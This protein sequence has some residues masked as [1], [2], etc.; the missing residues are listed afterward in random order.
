MSR[1]ARGW[2]RELPVVALFALVAVLLTR[3]HQK[4]DSPTFDEPLHVIA[5]A[6]Y[7]ENG[8]YAINLE[9]PPL[10]KILAGFSLR[11]LRV[12]PP[13]PGMRVP[14]M[15]GEYFQFL[16]GN[17]APASAI[18]SVARRPFPYLLAAL[19]LLAWLVAAAVFGEGVGLLAAGLVAFDPTFVGHAGVVHTDVGASLF[20]VA[21]VAGA[22]ASVR[23][24]SLAGW[25][26]TGVVL[27]LA[28]ATKFSAVLLIPFVAAVPFLPLGAP[29]GRSRVRDLA[30]AVAAIGV[31]TALLLATYSWAMRR[32]PL[33]TALDAEREYL[34]S[35]DAPP[36]TME[37][38]ARITH[39]SSPLGHY[40]TGLEGVALLDTNGR[41]ANYLLGRVSTDRFLSYFFVAFL[42]KSTPSFLLLTLFLVV[43][44]GRRL[45]DP[46]P[47]GLLL[48][49]ALFFV[50]AV[51]SHFNIGVRH[52]LP[53]YA[54]LA[55]AGAGV[56]ARRLNTRAFAWA[57]ASLVGAAALSVMTCHPEEIAYFNL[58]AGG[59]AGGE[60]WLTDS[61]I[62]WGQ[63]L[64]RVAEYLR[65][66]GWESETTVVAYSGLATNYYMRRIKTLDPSRPIEP[67]RYAVSALMQAIGPQFVRTF[68]GEESSRH[69]KAL[70]DALAA[71]GR[72][73]GRIAAS[74]TVWEL[75]PP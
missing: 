64:K 3:D 42:V 73:V 61:N 47:L 36:A 41:G 66:R 37:R 11:S 55:V 12:D 28:L 68:E 70:L 49:A 69:V 18:V 32:M 31:G 65:A 53:V 44:G 2:G 71:R 6:E 59:P 39:V 67:G 45:L 21:T 33:E 22:I 5:G 38:L 9:H 13:P 46:W 19:V 72:R 16:Y 7:V 27:G 24:G 40:L 17:R 23:R 54:L 25:L 50:A 52:I 56:L 60:R 57:G 8:T 63:D 35:R 51:R 15:H 26:G 30:Y 58:I 48:A 1:S 34:A 4:D 10:L 75:P 14:S 62:D 29:P 20:T 43:L 74:F